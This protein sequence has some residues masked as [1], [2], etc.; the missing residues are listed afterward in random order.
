[1]N[2]KNKTVKYFLIFSAFI[3]FCSCQK[4]R[5]EEQAKTDEAILLKYISDHKLNAQSIDSGIYYVI[6][7]TGSG[8]KPT[9]NSQVRVSYKGYFTNNSVFD[10]S[11][12]AGII[13]NLQ[14]V[15][16]GWTKGIPQF[17]EG[18]TGKLLIPSSMGYG[19]KGTIGIPPN[20][21]LIFDIHL[22]DVY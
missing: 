8:S 19:S 21:V 18:S 13:F 11:E 16:K 2:I 6:D 10:K 20:S 22:I 7:K 17:N 4:K 3:I 14:E 9:E 12:D 5:M 1:M 15:I